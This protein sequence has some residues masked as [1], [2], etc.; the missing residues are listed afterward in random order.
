MKIGEDGK[1]D[2]FQT[3]G[4][5][6]GVSHVVE[7]SVRRSGDRIR[8]TAQLIGGLASSADDAKPSAMPRLMS[9]LLITA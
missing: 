3:I 7:G 1:S 6:F 8:V 2:D 9:L 4:K 5:V